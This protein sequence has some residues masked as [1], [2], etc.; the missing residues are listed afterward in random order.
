L[1]RSF[2]TGRRKIFSPIK[3][4]VMA[5]TY[6]LI[7]IGE[8][9]TAVSAEYKQEHSEVPWKQISGMRNRLIHGYFATD[10]DIVWDTVSVY[11]PELVKQLETMIDHSGE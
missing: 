6:A 8:A 9:A 11:I 4:L 5:L 2:Q 3:T 10:P 7:I 1:F